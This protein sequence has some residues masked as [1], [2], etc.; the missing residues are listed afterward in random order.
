MSGRSTVVPPIR[1][2]SR[3][4][5]GWSA[6][7]H[8]PRVEFH[9]IIEGREVDFRFLGTPLI[10][11]CD[12]WAFHGLQR[13][14]FERDRSRDAMLIAAGWIVLRFT[15]RAITGTPG[16]V[17]RRISTALE[18]WALVEPPDAA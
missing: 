17:A 1:C 14:Q 10:V 8:L 3:R 18:R 13:E 6:R 16:S 5:G 11:E 2:S 12:G 7:Y 15:Y 4:C 9:P